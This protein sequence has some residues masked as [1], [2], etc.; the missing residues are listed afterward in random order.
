MLLNSGAHL[1]NLV[2]PRKH[3]STKKVRFGPFRVFVF[4]WEIT[5]VFTTKAISITPVSGRALDF[6]RA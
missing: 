6:A 5:L 3:G 1:M 4:S 2:Q